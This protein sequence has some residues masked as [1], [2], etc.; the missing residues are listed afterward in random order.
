[1]FILKGCSELWMLPPQSPAALLSCA[2][3]ELS[4]DAAAQHG[5]HLNELAL[6][7]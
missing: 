6:G 7:P 5:S 3:A 2:C 1:M 4:R